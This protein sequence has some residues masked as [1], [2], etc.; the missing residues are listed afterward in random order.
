MR[1]VSNPVP[2]CATPCNLFQRK[3]DIVCVTLCN[4]MKPSPWCVLCSYVCT[5]LYPFLSHKNINRKSHSILFI[6]Y[7][8]IIARIFIETFY[9]RPFSEKS[10]ISRFSQYN[11]KLIDCFNH[12]HIKGPLSTLQRSVYNN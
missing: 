6:F 11:W 10:V 3:R 1:G 4:L 7:I 12:L 8:E 5:H 2:P 9:F